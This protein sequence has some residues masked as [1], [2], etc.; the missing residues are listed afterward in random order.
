[1]R[2]VII[3]T[4]SH[5]GRLD[6]WYVNS[7][8]QTLKH[9]PSDLQVDP[10]FVS[11]D[12]LVQRARNSTAKIAMDGQYD[13]LFFIDSDVEWHPDWFFKI[14]SHPEDI[15]GAALVKKSE[16]ES[17]TCKITNHNLKRNSRQ[18][19]IE[20]DG[21][22]TGFL[23]ISKKALTQLWQSSLPYKKEEGKTEEERMIFDIAV[24]NGILISEDYIMCEKWKN[25]GNKIYMDP[26][27]TINHVGPKKY[28]GNISNFLNKA[29]YR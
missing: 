1:M 24:K 20:V 13:D 9:C 18:D 28:T 19:L 27:F 10:I 17:Y 15:V 12:S 23:K 3:G 26:S 25:M 11:F 14:L 7:L 8:I 5:D 29:G 6:V 4:P 21:I 22:G 2:K 16:E